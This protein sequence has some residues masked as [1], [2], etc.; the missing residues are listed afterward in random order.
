MLES[1]TPA[2]TACWTKLQ[3]SPRMEIVSPAGGG[4]QIA[5]AW[6]IWPAP[7]ERENVRLDTSPRERAY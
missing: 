4:L 1:G 5:F 2:G 7:A 3:N 6:S